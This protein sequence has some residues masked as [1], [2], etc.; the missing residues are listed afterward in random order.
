VKRAIAAEGD[1]LAQPIEIDPKTFLRDHCTL[2]VLPKV[3][4]RLQE[5][6][7]D[8]DVD[9]NKIADLINS[10]AAILA[11]VLKIVNSAYYGLPT[12]IKN[13]RVA[14]AFLGIHEIHRIVI[15]LAVIKN[16]AIQ[17]KKELDEF[18]FHSFLTARCAKYLAKKF[19]PLLSYEDLWPAAMLHD[20][21]KLVYLKFFPDHY[22]QIK[23]FSVQ[24]GVM[25]HEAERYYGYPTSAF[26]GSLLCGY[27]RLPVQAKIGCEFHTL[28]DL[29]SVS[30]KN[31]PRPIERVIS[32]A[33][34]VAILCSDG[35][36]NETRERIF[37]AV[38]KELNCS[39]QEFVALMGDVYQLK[40]E[41]EHLV[42]QFC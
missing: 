31:P 7:L 29:T 6:I 13:V 33:N 3:V 22:R 5:M 2:P 38:Q 14:V 4:G 15:S 27:W 40:T 19:E 25:F 21:G 10:D 35:L 30:K 17:Q 42:G 20:I 18:W 11:Q 36:S 39:Q 28:E 32:L 23:D 12:E 8:V 37:E 26:L 34:L 41:V 9:L 24:Q 1:I 16:L